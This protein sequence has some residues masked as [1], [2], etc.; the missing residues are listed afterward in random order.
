MLGSRWSW[1]VVFQ[2]KVVDVDGMKVKLQV[3]GG[4][5]V[6]KAG[7]PWEGPGSTDGCSHPGCRSGTRLARSGSAASPTPTT[8]T[9]TVSTGPGPQASAP[10]G[11]PGCE[12]ARSGKGGATRRRWGAGAMAPEILTPLT[13]ST[14]AAV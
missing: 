12:G 14:A 5:G 8:V 9:P 11:H 2:N 10:G 6:V 13:P 4:G 7:G 1:L 3:R